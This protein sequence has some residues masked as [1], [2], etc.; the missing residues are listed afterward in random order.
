MLR[1]GLLRPPPH[2]LSLRLP[3]RPLSRQATMFRRGPEAGVVP[4][5]RA[6]RQAG[7]QGRLPEPTQTPCLGP[8]LGKTSKDSEGLGRTRKDSEGRF[9]PAVR[10][11]AKT[12]MLRVSPARVPSACTSWAG[13][14]V[15][16]CPP[17]ENKVL[18]RFVYRHGIE[19]MQIVRSLFIPS[20]DTF[21]NSFFFLAPSSLH[22]PPGRRRRRGEYGSRRSRDGPLP[23]W[24]GAADVQGREAAGARKK[25]AALPSAVDPTAILP[26]PAV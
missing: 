9:G 22:R 16:S 15:F 19:L 26:A 5:C 4:R 14:T 20:C 7:R 8:E 1:E 11:P 3:P 21:R 18:P 24:A 23:P 6:P 2:P 13:R 12:G 17:T 10:S 25:A